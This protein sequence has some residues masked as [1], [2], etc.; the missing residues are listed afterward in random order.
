MQHASADF[1]ERKHDIWNL[2]EGIVFSCRI[3]KV[4]PEP[5]IYEY[6]LREHGLD[7]AET[8]FIDDLKENLEA[9]AAFGIRTV[10]FVSPAQCKAD[11]TKLDC[12]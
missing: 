8:V 12:L 11:L 5:G 1:L 3:Q 10:Q 4:K 6:L 2:F 9:A 7:P